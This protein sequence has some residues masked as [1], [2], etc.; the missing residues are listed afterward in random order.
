MEETGRTGR[1]QIVISQVPFQVNKATMVEKIAQLSRDRKIEGISDVRDES[2]RHGL[3]VVIELRGSTDPEYVL[4]NLYEHTPLQTAFNLNMLALV[5]GQPKELHLH[6]FLHHFI[7]FRVE[8]VTRRAQFDLKK[9]QE[10]AHIL[11]GLRVAV[12]QLEA[13]IAT[14]RAADDAEKAREALITQFSLT[15]EQAQAILDMQLRR[16]TAL[17]RQRLEEEYQG[18]QRTI[19]QL[20]TLLAD[21]QKVM[22]EV[23]REIRKVQKDFGNPRR[24]EVLAEEG[25]RQTREELEPHAD[26]VLTLSRNG[27]IK[28]VPVTTY[29]LQH[30]G[31]K[32]VSGMTTR[33]D[34]VVPH[35]L[36]ADTHDTL[37][38]F[39]QRGKVYS[40]RCYD[41]LETSRTSRGTP[42]VNL[43][44]ALLPNDQGH[45]HGGGAGPAPGRRPRAGHPYGGDQAGALGAVR[46]HPQQRHHRHGPGARR[47][48]HL[49]TAPHRR[50]RG[51]RRH[52]QRHVRL[53]P[54]LPAPGALPHRRRG[55]RHPPEAGRPRGQHG[56][57]GPRWPPPD[58]Q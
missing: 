21:P 32:G 29:R 24:T 1:S 5:D 39:T 55:S 27:Y 28:R 47:P 48:A 2:D 19:A 23:K 42:V 36:T 3:R 9:A 33:E 53:L 13:V 46:Q 45:R 44:P 52:R 6:H 54:R 10:R 57:S 51:H 26:V 31:G 35:M 15:Q 12:D 7:E 16:L 56:H 38:F 4:S 8:V 41:I 49:R 58:R 20:E 18:L 50:Q 40:I 43:I 14:I 17:D 25:R 22:T 11:E 37:L 30:R 34:D